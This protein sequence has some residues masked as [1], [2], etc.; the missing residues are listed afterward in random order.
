MGTTMA[1]TEATCMALAVKTPEMDVDDRIDPIEDPTMADIKSRVAAGYEVDA[2]QVA[3]RS[4]ASSAWS[5][6]LGRSS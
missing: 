2:E 4:C 3:R 6:G 1:G 5:S